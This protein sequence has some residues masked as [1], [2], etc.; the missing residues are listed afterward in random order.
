MKY[1]L[2]G[3]GKLCLFPFFYLIWILLLGIALIQI[4]GGKK[5]YDEE[6]LWEQFGNWYLN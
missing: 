4:L 2:I 5:F 1:F 6:P 3:L